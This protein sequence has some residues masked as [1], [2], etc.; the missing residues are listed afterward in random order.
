MEAQY[1][2]WRERTRRWITRDRPMALAVTTLAFCLMVGIAMAFIP[3]GDQAAVSTA[4]TPTPPSSQIGAS[5]DMA[6]SNLAKDELN[7]TAHRTTDATTPTS[8]APTATP[9]AESQTPLNLSD[10]SSDSLFGGTQQ[11]VW[12]TFMDM[13]WKLGLVLALIYL[14]LRALAVLK[15]KG[16]PLATRAKEAKPTKPREGLIEELDIIP[17][18]DNHTL[19]VVR[20]GLRVLLLVEADGALQPLTE[21]SIEEYEPALAN[22]DAEDTFRDQFLKIW[23]D[24][25]NITPATEHGKT[26]AP[27]AESAPSPVIPDVQPTLPPLPKRSVPPTMED[28][29]QPVHNTPI[30][31]NPFVELPAFDVLPETNELA[32]SILPEREATITPA[33]NASGTPSRRRT[34]KTTV[35]IGHDHVAEPHA[36]QLQ[37]D[38]E[39]PIAAPAPSR[40]TGRGRK[41]VE[42]TPALLINQSI[43]PVESMPP[44]EAQLTPVTERATAALSLPTVPSRSQQEETPTN[45]QADSTKSRPTAKGRSYFD[46]VSSHVP[47]T[48]STQNV[49]PISRQ[50]Q[51]EDPIIPQNPI[52]RYPSAVD[53]ND[54][55]DSS[56]DAMPAITAQHSSKLAYEQSD[57]MTGGPDDREV[58]WY[59]E[60]HG[61]VATAARYRLTAQQL[62]DIQT[63]YERKRAEQAAAAERERL[64]A[65]ERERAERE[66]RERLAAM[67]SERERRERLAAATQ[68]S[69]AALPPVPPV[70]DRTSGNTGLLPRSSM[71]GSIYGRPP[72]VTPP[73]NTARKAP[74]S[75]EKDPTAD[76][77]AE[78]IA[79]ALAERFKTDT[80]KK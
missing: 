29:V 53:V 43:E 1:H 7:R 36:I 59:A 2:Y 25:E 6:H 64:A 33:Q 10:P 19:H 71:L 3:A 8:T 73:A 14:S 62:S 34:K 32:P 61:F 67:D 52:L 74:T 21:M 75:A 45:L 40:R 49:T 50:T 18:T 46:L 51:L 12:R 31:R 44:P 38:A 79:R 63:R 70:P 37:I 80:T 60:T 66:E 55:E 26:S 5:R 27:I 42:E 58:L 30:N 77:L 68:A 4:A 23:Q 78:T 57:V 48:P 28:A 69:R 76:L 54:E 16:L 56:A 17:L 11:P 65:L 24:I 39:T 9:N 41:P 72:A 13:I 20:L 35:N 47:P 15:I 22:K